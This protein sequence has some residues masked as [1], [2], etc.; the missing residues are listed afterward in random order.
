MEI[1]KSSK[2]ILASG[3]ILIIYGYLCRL[4]NLYFFWESKSLGWSIVLIGIITLLINRIKL[5]KIKKENAILEKIGIGVTTF[6]L[7]VQSIFMFIIPKTD[8]CKFAESYLKNDLKLKKEIGNVI[9]YSYLQT[10]NIQ[11]SSGADGDSGSAQFNFTVKG[12][13]KFKDITIYLVKYID[14][15]QWQIEGVE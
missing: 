1:N 8:A 15:P 13:K 10:G 7:L 2:L 12:D 3:L 4:I 5:K 11:V 9:G 14:N 6:I